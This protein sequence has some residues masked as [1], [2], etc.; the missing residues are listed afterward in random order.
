MKVRPEVSAVRFGKNRITRTSTS[1][2]TTMSRRLSFF[3]FLAIITSTIW[4]TV[5]N[6]LEPHQTVNVGLVRFAGIPLD[7][8]VRLEWDT[9]TELGTAGYKLKRG[10]NNAL[11]YLAAPG[12][13]G[14]LF[15]GSEGGPNQGYEYAYTDNTAVNGERYTYQ[16]V[17]V[18]VDGSEIPLA[19]TTVTAGIVPT[20]TSIVVSGGGGGGSKNT[21]TSNTTEPT[22][23][24]T[25]TLSATPQTTNTLVPTTTPLSTSAPAPPATATQAPSY[26]GQEPAPQSDPAAGVLAQPTE[27]PFQRNA[28]DESSQADSFVVAVALAQE[29]PAMEES[30]LFPDSETI[31]HTQ[32]ALLYAN[33]TVIGASPRA[34]EEGAIQDDPVRPLV[35][36]RNQNPGDS[37]S[38]APEMQDAETGTPISSMAGRIYLWAAFIAALVI[39]VA[40]VIGAI[41]IYTRQRS[42][43]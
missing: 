3:L 28:S 33:Y 23:T 35:I 16:L 13:S 34:T 41:L 15:I 37:S 36:T 18:E 14:D 32:Y 17:E 10:Q 2:K 20:A 27:E 25:V 1:N 24:P 43:E 4:S 38:P 22:A 39:F 29:E 30:N 7:N 11:A 21:P 8:A 19:D 40:A 26:P 5:G 9:E 42:K 12:G 6:A 31:A